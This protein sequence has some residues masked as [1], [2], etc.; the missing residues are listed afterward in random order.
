MTFKYGLGDSPDPIYLFVSES[1]DTDG[2]VHPWHMFDHDAKKPIPVK[3]RALTGVIAGLRMKM[4]SFKDKASVKLQ[5]TITPPP[6]EDGQPYVVQSGVET[7]FTRGVL[8]ALDL[9]DDYSQPLTLVVANGGEKVVF[10]RL[11]RAHNGERVKVM[12]DKERKIFPL[13]QQLQRKLGQQAQSWAD[14]QETLQRNAPPLRNGNEEPEYVD[15][16]PESPF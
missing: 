5:I 15:E 7:T 6:G 1:I 16:T 14:V 4:T 12:W 3:S 13:I 8:L 2:E 10:G 11:H 9:V